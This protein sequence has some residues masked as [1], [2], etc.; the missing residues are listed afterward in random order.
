MGSKG[1]LRIVSVTV[2]T[3]QPL[4]FSPSSEQISSLKP[5][6]EAPY[7]GIRRLSPSSVFDAMNTW[8]LAI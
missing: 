3:P 1:L 6:A 7:I 5:F 8:K 4:F 2:A